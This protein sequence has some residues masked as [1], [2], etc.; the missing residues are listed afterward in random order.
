MKRWI[1]G[2]VFVNLLYV[3]IVEAEY[4]VGDSVYIPLNQYYVV[5]Q[6]DYPVKV[7]GNEYVPAVIK[8]KD[9]N[10]YVAVIDSIKYVYTTTGPGGVIVVDSVVVVFDPATVDSNI[11]LIVSTF[12]NPDGSG[13]SIKQKVLNYLGITES[14]LYDSDND[15]R[16]FI[17]F[18]GLFTSSRI[19]NLSVYGYFDPYFSTTEKFPRHE[20]IVLNVNNGTLYSDGYL[21]PNILKKTLFYTYSQYALWSIDPEEL[22]I[23]LSKEAF[24]IASQADPLGSYYMG[25][26]NSISL[27]APINPFSVTVPYLYGKYM[28]SDM[29]GEIA[30]YFFRN[31]SYYLGD[32]VLLDIIK[33]PYIFDRALKLALESNGLSLADVI[34]DFHLRNLFNASGKFGYSYDDPELAGVEIYRPQ[35]FAIPPTAQSSAYTVSAYGA[36]LVYPK[37]VSQANKYFVLNYPDSA[38]QQGLMVYFVDVVNDSFYQITVPDRYDRPSGL[39]KG[40]QWI[41]IIN[42]S[43]QSVPFS[44]GLDTIPPADYSFNVFTTRFDLTKFYITVVSP[45]E[46]AEDVDKPYLLV[47][48]QSPLGALEFDLNLTGELVVGIGQKRYVYYK[49]VKFPT[50]APGNYIFSIAPKDL[51][52]NVGERVADT[53][54]VEYLNQNSV[55]TLSNGVDIVGEGYVIVNVVDEG[56]YIHPSGRVQLRFNTPDASR[57]VYYR[58][59]ME[60]MWQPL[61]TY[62]DDG[63]VYVNTNMPGFYKTGFGTPKNGSFSLSYSAGELVMNVPYP[64]SISLEIYD[65]SGKKVYSHVRRV[66]MPGTISVSPELPRGVY[67]LKVQYGDLKI[68]RKLVFID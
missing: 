28:V 67:V 63:Y 39:D 45:D 16:I 56:V 46:L 24:Y 58:A 5:P 27:I 64:G 40:T 6:R 15:P 20:L 38:F 7:G 30:Y 47:S 26:D 51:V 10:I 57:I 41:Y 19:S 34:K 62:Y 18:T 48:L 33:S 52:E 13:E 53:L 44:V 59:S 22:D 55:L 3:G 60:D 1:L 42:A 11:S 8:Y 61:D 23:Y 14:D 32:D 17:V 9:D 68:T 29:D 4:D 66:D 65:I 31:V 49:E 25:F 37:V 35:V 43:S 50:L 2:L 12:N 36:S 54:I 21:D